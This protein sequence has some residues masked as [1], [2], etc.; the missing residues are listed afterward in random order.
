[1]SHALHCAASFGDG[2]DCECFH[3][4]HECHTIIPG[5]C[6]WNERD[7][8][9]VDKHHKASETTDFPTWQPTDLPTSDPT[10]SKSTTFPIIKCGDTL[11]DIA[12]SEPVIWRFDLSLDAT[13]I[14]INACNSNY[15]TILKLFNDKPSIAK[16]PIFADDEGCDNQHSSSLI[17]SK[18]PLFAGTYYLELTANSVKKHSKYEINIIC[19]EVRETPEPETC[20]KCNAMNVKMVDYGH[21]HEYDT[22]H[23]EDDDG[24]EDVVCY[25][26]KMEKLYD[27]EMCPQNVNN[28]ILGVCNDDYNELK[29]EDLD[30]LIV[31]KYG[32][33]TFQVFKGDDIFGIKV[34]VEGNQEPIEF[35][36]CM[37]GINDDGKMGDLV[38]FQRDE[39]EPFLCRDRTND[40]LPCL[41]LV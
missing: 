21:F 3:G 30:A 13:S 9:C 32:G 11:Q 35:T 41:R 5:K 8:E 12:S 19:N 16:I 36:L 4:H 25:T 31:R 34:D 29:E 24:N 10:A 39:N 20:D 40:G 6:L 37:K 1:M 2:R 14:E 23:I 22:K 33:D 38:R 18:K 27:A 28:V 7:S 26:Y 17:I 15:D